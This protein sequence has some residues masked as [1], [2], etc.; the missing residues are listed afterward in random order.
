MPLRRTRYPWRGRGY[1]SAGLSPCPR[2]RAAREPR[3]GRR[4]EGGY[5]D[6]VVAVPSG[7]QDLATVSLG[8]YGAEARVQRCLAE[9]Q[10]SE[11]GAESEIVSHPSGGREHR[12][13]PSVRPYV[14]S[15]EIVF[16]KPS[17]PVLATQKRASSPPTG[18]TVSTASSAI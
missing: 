18:A 4:G 2:A 11:A 16:I 1:V 15:P 5:V 7:V 9:K 12:Q 6:D 8:F 3:C 10:A 17:G 13:S 14:S